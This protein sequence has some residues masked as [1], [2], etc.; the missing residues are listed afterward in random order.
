MRSCWRWVSTEMYLYDQCAPSSPIWLYFLSMRRQ[1][2]QPTDS[3]HLHL[4]SPR[5]LLTNTSIRAILSC[6]LTDPRLI[7]QHV[8]TCNPLPFSQHVY[9][10]TLTFWIGCGAGVQ[11]RSRL[12]FSATLPSRRSRTLFS[13]PTMC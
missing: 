11:T 9:T 5:F 13:P 6:I 10:S 7:P 12:Y 1:A 3:D 8:F 2:P 4:F